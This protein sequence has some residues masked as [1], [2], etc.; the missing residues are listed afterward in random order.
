MKHANGQLILDL[1]FN[2]VKKNRTIKICLTDIYEMWDIY[3]HMRQK[4]DIFAAFSVCMII[5]FT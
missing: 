2:F 4:D 1:V 5:C 3:Q